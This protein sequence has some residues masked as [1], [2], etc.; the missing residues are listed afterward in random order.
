M[1]S[2][3]LEQIQLH[4]G[5][6][7]IIDNVILFIDILRNFKMM[8]LETKEQKDFSIPN[9]LSIHSFENKVLL[10]TLENNKFTQKLF[11]FEGELQL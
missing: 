9:C 5:Q 10:Q 3:Q 6:F 4:L 7:T 2:E 1:K 11:L 8:N